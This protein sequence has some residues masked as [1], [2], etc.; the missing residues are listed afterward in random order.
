M[1]GRLLIF[2][3]IGIAAVALAV[4]FV[5]SS[6]KGAHLELTGKVLK[7]RTGALDEQHSVAVLD[8]RLENPSDIRF[9]VRLL[10]VRLDK[11]D[12]SSE[13]GSQVS[14][15]DLERLFAYNKFLGQRYNE[16]L[17]IRDLIAPHSAAD[18]MTAVTFDVAVKE[19]ESA[20]K[21]H[22]KIQDVDGPVFETDT[23]VQ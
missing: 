1:S 2:V 22:L 14:K 18:R 6:T 13:D 16:S 11:A 9:V 5:M 19:L 23:K 10:E 15:R 8:Y 7:V 4:F 12:G 3:A 17:S 20:K 21:L